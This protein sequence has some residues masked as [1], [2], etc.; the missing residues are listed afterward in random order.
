MSTVTPQRAKQL[1]DLCRSKI[2]CPASASAPCIPFEYPDDGCWGRAHEMCRL[3]ILD[4]AQPDK[5]W[6][7]GGCIRH[8]RT[9][10][11]AS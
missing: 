8:R 7:K 2:C 9:S 11:A 6:I 3:M 5:V 4:G 10:P 1:F